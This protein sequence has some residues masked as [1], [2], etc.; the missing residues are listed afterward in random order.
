MLYKA[1]DPMHVDAYGLANLMLRQ[2]SQGQLD[3]KHV[4]QNFFCPGSN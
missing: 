3:D 2:P 1:T 4:A